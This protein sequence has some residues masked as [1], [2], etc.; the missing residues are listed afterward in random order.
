MM[1]GFSGHHV[2]VELGRTTDRLAGVVDDEIQPVAG[3]SSIC[4]QNASTLGVWRKSSPKI[5]RRSLHSS[6][7]ASRALPRRRVPRKA[8]R[9]DEVRARA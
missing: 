6:K 2:G 5:S 1:R 9:D 4:R 3:S 8:R 7:S